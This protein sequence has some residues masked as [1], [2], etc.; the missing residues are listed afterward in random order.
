MNEIIESAE[1]TK[2]VALHRKICANAQAAQESLWEVCRGLKEMH[3]SKLFRE[4]GFSTFKEYCEKKLEVTD[5]QARNYIALADSFTEEERKSISAFGTTKL[6]LLARLD[7]PQREEIQ[8]TVNVGDV[9]VRELKAKIAE[10][11]KDLK[12][13]QANYSMHTKRRDD[14]ISGYKERQEKL[15]TRNKELVQELEKNEDRRDK[16]DDELEEAIDQRDEA[17]ETIHSLEKQIE[18][19]EKRPVEV[20]VQTETKTDITA[21]FNAYAQAATDA[22]KHL[23]QFC[24][25]NSDSSEKNLFVSKLKMIVSLTE[26]SIKNIGGI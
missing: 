8:Q 24:E 4:L 14:E 12:T 22:M 15:L 1:Y 6:L 17:Y 18:E 11:E 26:Q 3:D 10:L 20:A 21:V 2:A 16:L 23:T 9:S 25:K 5:R 7:E 19:L 13:Q